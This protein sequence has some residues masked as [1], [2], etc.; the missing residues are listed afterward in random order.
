MEP[1]TTP[2]EAPRWVRIARRW[3]AITYATLCLL[4]FV[5]VLQNLDPT[6]LDLLFWSVGEVPKLVLVLGSMAIGVL[7]WELGRLLLLGRRHLRKP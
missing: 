5:I 6:R 3:R 1:T 7:L 2:E 4:L